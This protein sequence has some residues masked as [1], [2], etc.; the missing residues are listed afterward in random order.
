MDD[1][2]TCRPVDLS[3]SPGT[4]RCQ[5][6]TV[7]AGDT[8]DKVA[9]QFGVALDEL[10]ALNPD[11]RDGGRGGATLECA[12]ATLVALLG[13]GQPSDCC[14]IV[15]PGPPC[16]SA[17]TSAWPPPLPLATPAAGKPPDWTGAAD[18]ALRRLLRGGHARVGARR[19]GRTCPCLNK[20]CT[21]CRC[22]LSI[23]CSARDPESW[24]YQGE[25]HLPMPG[26]APADSLICR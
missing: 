10:A 8:G 21:G 13:L 11:V 2:L 24:P 3:R 19:G 6:Y 25:D 12:G 15:L 9:S 17:L 18:P 20:T 23:S 26:T 22:T 16:S 14:M 7:K 5:V 1:W 4:V